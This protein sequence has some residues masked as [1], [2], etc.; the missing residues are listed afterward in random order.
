MNEIINI[1]MKRDSISY[2]EARAI[3]EQCIKDLEEAF[4]T[5]DYEL[6]TDIIAYD[7]GL[8]PDYLECFL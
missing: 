8:E 1:L 4:A 7:L 6:A 5:G 2:R 3:V